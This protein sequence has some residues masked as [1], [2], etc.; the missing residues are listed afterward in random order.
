MSFPKRSYL[1]EILTAC[2]QNKAHSIRSTRSASELQAHMD[3]I[4][5]SALEVISQTGGMESSFLPVD[6]SSGPQF[7]FQTHDASTTAAS[8]ALDAMDHS[9]S[10]IAG[11]SHFPMND[12]MLTATI[13]GMHMAELS[14]QQQ[15][16]KHQRKQ[17]RETPP[18]LDAFSDL[19]NSVDGGGGVG[20]ARRPPLA[21]RYGTPPRKSTSAAPI[22]QRNASV[23]SDGLL[24][25]TELVSPDVL[26]DDAELGDI[27]TWGWWPGASEAEL[28][29]I[30]GDSR[31]SNASAKL[32]TCSESRRF[33]ATASMDG[34]IRIWDADNLVCV[35]E[36]HGHV[37]GVRHVV[38]ADRARNNMLLLATAAVDGTVIIWV[39]NM[40]GELQEQFILM[41]HEQQ[42]TSIV[43]T[44][45][46]RKLISAGADGAVCIWRVSTGTF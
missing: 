46:S 24:E 10:S 8:V 15:Q 22:Q 35:N 1:T 11:S 41:R 32:G 37:D 39:L 4:V 34:T 42:V 31:R 30:G 12:A 33:V 23:D 28:S 17:V 9:S 16:L 36:L 43:F 18:E 25:Y 40:D 38:W 7:N 45:D 3:Q 21:G 2:R 14:M 6:G 19:F 44:P 20:G 29:T 13:D 5:N 26:N 27:Q